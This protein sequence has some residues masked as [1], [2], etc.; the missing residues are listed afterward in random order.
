MI[1]PEKKKLFNFYLDDDIKNEANEKLVRLT[2]EKPKGQ[3]ASLIRVLLK[4]FVSTPDNKINPL[5]IEAIEA[6][7][8]Y[9]S[10]MNKRSRN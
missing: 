2:G 8:E 7:Y 6:E 1:T 4:Q 9:T 3:L 10:K 5:L